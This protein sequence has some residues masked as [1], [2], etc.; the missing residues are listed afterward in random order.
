M[1][2]TC[3]LNQAPAAPFA[4]A[5]CRPKPPAKKSAADDFLDGL[6]RER[7]ADADPE[8]DPEAAAEAAAR[9]RALFDRLTE[10]AVRPPAEKRVAGRGGV[11]AC[12]REGSSQTL[13]LRVRRVS[14]F[15][16]SACPSQ[17]ALLE[18]GFED[19]YQDTKESIADSL[20]GSGGQGCGLADQCVEHNT[21]AVPARVLRRAERRSGP[22]G[23]WG[24]GLHCCGCRSVSA[25][26]PSFLVLSREHLANIP[27]I[28]GAYAVR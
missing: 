9:T 14:V 25:L 15:R 3:V 18:L 13:P 16:G 5:H 19:I 4:F 7:T 2:H 21:K 10:H 6:D 27:W 28:S 17:S 12:E 11:G 8:A 23:R 1:R 22:A 20:R 24:R 26:C